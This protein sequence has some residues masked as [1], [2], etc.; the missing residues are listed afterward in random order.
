MTFDFAR[1]QRSKPIV[2][3]RVEGL[4][5]SNFRIS[6]QPDSDLRSFAQ[7]DVVFGPHIKATS[8]FL[9]REGFELFQ[10]V[11]ASDSAGGSG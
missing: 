1:L 11:A 7:R 4:G 3:V 2:N 8:F 10:T 6:P 5:V 9:K